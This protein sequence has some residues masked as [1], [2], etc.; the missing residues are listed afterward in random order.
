MKRQK[1]SREEKE[2]KFIFSNE[3]S[4]ENKEWEKICNKQ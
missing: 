3:E 1:H 2:E 4:E